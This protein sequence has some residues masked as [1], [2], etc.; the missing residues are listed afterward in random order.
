MVLQPGSPPPAQ[1]VLAPARVGSRGRGPGRRLAAR[2]HYPLLRPSVR[3]RAARRATS[4]R[5]PAGWRGLGSPRHCAAG[6]A[7]DPRSTCPA[8]QLEGPGAPRGAGPPAP[9]PPGAAPRPARWSARR[10]EPGSE[11]PRSLR[12]GAPPRPGVPRPPRPVARAAHPRNWRA[13]AG[14]DLGDSRRHRRRHNLAHLNGPGAAG[15]RAR[16]PAGGV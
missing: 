2:P 11:E 10:A 15:G 8:P 13:P 14:G 7:I 5:C 3:R 16:A 9:A 4:D 1:L 12:P 6:A